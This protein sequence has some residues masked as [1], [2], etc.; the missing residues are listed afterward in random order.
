MNFTSDIP[1]EPGA[2]W[3]KPDEVTTYAVV[4]HLDNWFDW[5][6]SARKRGGLWSEPLEPR[7][8]RCVWK[9]VT[10]LHVGI[11][12]KSGC[13]IL[14]VVIKPYTFCPFCGGEIEIQ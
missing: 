5:K 6:E 1:T 3:W 7:K 2:Y 9:R 10:T 12:W 4:I 13:G 8:P 14:K 11:P